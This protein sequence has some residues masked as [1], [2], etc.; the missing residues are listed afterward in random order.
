[1]LTVETKWGRIRALQRGR[2]NLAA[3]LGVTDEVLDEAA[4]LVRT[5]YKCN[6]PGQTTGTGYLHIAIPV[7]LH[8]LLSNMST[9]MQRA[10]KTVVR[11]LLHAAMQSKLEPPH[12]VNKIRYKKQV[13]RGKVVTGKQVCLWL[14]LTVGLREAIHRRALAYGSTPH[15]YCRAWIQALVDGNLG[16]LDIQ[17]LDN[18]GQL[19]DSVQAYQLP[20]VTDEGTRKDA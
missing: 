14:R 15:A 16:D 18:R 5:G 4:H 1:M 8:V 7:E 3:E 13:L 12:A 19:F 10:P 6:K 9:L 20:E 2:E 11:D 17:P